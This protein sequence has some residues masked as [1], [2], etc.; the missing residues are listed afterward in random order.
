MSFC[1][2]VDKYK[3]TTDRLEACYKGFVK[4]TDYKISFFKTVEE[5]LCVCVCVQKAPMIR[6]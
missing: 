5:D 6:F 2:E 4:T 3:K 1:V